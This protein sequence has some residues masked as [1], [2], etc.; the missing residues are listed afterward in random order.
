[1]KVYVIR[2][3]QSETNVNKRYTGW[4]QVNLTQQ[5]I[6]EAKSIRP[7][8]QDVKFD[9]IFSS[10]LIRAMQTA[11]NA[12]PGC[13]YETD[14]MLREVGMGSLEM[15]PIDDVIADMRAKNT[16]EL[17][18]AMYGGESREDFLSRVT[19]FQEYLQTL[20]CENVAVFSHW[21]WIKELLNQILGFRI[22]NENIVGKNCCVAVFEY[23]NAHW[24]LHSFIN[25]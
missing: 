2:H 21:G 10:D 7:I 3:G 17:G 11:E 19:R 12:I 16:R 8:L 14:P 24:K 4:S 15:Q 13:T 5:G 18:Y 9:R 23:E 1:M 25:Q 20:D 6:D 22:P